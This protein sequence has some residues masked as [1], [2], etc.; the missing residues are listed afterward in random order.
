MTSVAIIGGGIGGLC[1]AQGLRRA[2]VAVTV[3]EKTA[4]RTDWLQG[5]RIHINPHGSRA[6][7]DCLEPAGWKA[8]L[9][10]VSASAG[11]FGFV[12][13]QLHDL[14]RFRG[15]EISQ[16]ADPAERHYGVSRIRLRQ[17]L[18]DG[19]DDAVHLGK[20]FERY[21]VGHDGKVLA[22]FEDGDEVTADLLIGADGSNSLVRTQ[23]LPHAAG[24]V[25]TGVIAIAGKHRLPAD[26]AQA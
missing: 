4:E 11:G 21:S 9:D 14:L 15:D 18:L 8:F 26:L 13:E 5:Y 7:H 2:G 17:I 20:T 12:T 23:L 3:Y 24:R 6:L 19:M 10:T 1:L 22:H 16:S 25:D